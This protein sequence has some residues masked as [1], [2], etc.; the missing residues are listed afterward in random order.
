MPRKGRV[1][2]RESLDE[3]G[4]HLLRRELEVAGDERRQS[5]VRLPLFARAGK[6][7]GLPMVEVA[8]TSGLSR[9]GAY[10][11]VDRDIDSGHDRTWGLD[12]ALIALLSV[13][14][15]LSAQTADTILR[16][17]SSEVWQQLEQLVSDGIVH[18][19]VGEQGN[20]PIPHYALNGDTATQA[21]TR[22]L[23]DIRGVRADGYSVYYAVAPD[24]IAPIKRAAN[25]MVRT[26]EWELIPLGNN[27]AAKTDELAVVVRGPDR[28]TALETA[29]ELWQLIAE[30]AGVRRGAVIAQII[31]PA[32][33]RPAA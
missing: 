28:R 19:L 1:M 23:E 7:A 17:G 6:G 15:P 20:P 8:R 25:E 30:R 31:D 11:A 27:S 24:E 18:R 13:R 5:Q 9:K 3:L 10:D 22:R 33:L 32:R 21:M 12:M 2:R 16:V 26:D 4:R 14:G 29:E